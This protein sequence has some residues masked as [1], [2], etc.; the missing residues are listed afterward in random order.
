[1]TREPRRFYFWNILALQGPQAENA[2]SIVTVLASQEYTVIQ[3]ETTTRCQVRFGG[4]HRASYF[5]AQASS[6]NVAVEHW[7]HIRKQI[8]IIY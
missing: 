7:N 5:V 1:M 2:L 6:S 3:P 4:C 8:S